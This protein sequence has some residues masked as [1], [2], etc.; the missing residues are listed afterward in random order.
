MK[1]YFLF[2]PL[3][4]LVYGCG[5]KVDDVMELVQTT[6]L[7]DTY[8]YCIRVNGNKKYCECEVSDLR[9]TF[10]WDLYIKKIDEIAGEENHIGKV[11][12]KYNGDRIKILEELNCDTCPFSIALTVADVSPSKE[13]VA[14]L[15]Y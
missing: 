1:K 5:D 7:K 14:I 8:D 6:T 9:K 11:I 2:L 15:G 4:F 13:C 10:P 3:I 12:S